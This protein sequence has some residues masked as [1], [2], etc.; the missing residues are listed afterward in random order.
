MWESV[1]YSMF[2]LV[3]GIATISIFFAIRNTVRK[4]DKKSKRDL[5]EYDHHLAN[6]RITL[7]KVSDTENA[8]TSVL[9]LES[10]Y[11]IVKMQLKREGSSEMTTEKK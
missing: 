7:D 6:V 2:A 5:E 4:R 10:L 8:T 1:I 9:L 11:K 3:G